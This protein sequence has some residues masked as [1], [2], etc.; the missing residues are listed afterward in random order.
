MGTVFVF[1]KDWIL[2]RV[3]DV[4][5]LRA[6][7]NI[8][9]LRSCARA[10]RPNDLASKILKRVDIKKNGVGFLKYPFDVW[11]CTV[12]PEILINARNKS[13]RF[14]APWDLFQSALTLLVGYLRSR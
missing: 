14:S 2:K 5:P 9:L 4:F 11:K 3:L 10:Y 12:V 7:A 6:H 8:V 13:D 1:P